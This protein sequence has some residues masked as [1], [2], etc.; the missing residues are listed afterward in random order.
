MGDDLR[1]L[2][3]VAPQSVPRLDHSPE[4]LDRCHFH[5]LRNSYVRLAYSYLQRENCVQQGEQAH[6]VSFGPS[7]TFR[8]DAY[9]L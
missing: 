8:Y 1:S 2:V 4:F 3:Y 5:L 9:L 7:E 6:L